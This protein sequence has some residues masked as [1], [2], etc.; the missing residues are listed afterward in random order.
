MIQE[1][2]DKGLWKGSIRNAEKYVMPWLL[3]QTFDNLVIGER[4]GEELDDRKKLLVGKYGLSS[5]APIGTVRSIL[6]GDFLTPPAIDALLTGTVRPIL[7][8]DPERLADSLQRS[9]TGFTPGYVLY[10]FLG[11][12]LPTY[13]TGEK[14]E[15]EEE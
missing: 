12:D 4:V 14:P 6:A 15:K 2:R 9:L 7:D 11:T 5:S 1:M 8:G 13:V 3:L 10:R